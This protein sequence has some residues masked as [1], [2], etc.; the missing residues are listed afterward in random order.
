[1][2]S[3]FKFVLNVKTAE[4]FRPKFL[5]GNSQEKK[6]INPHTA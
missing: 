6:T 5:F 1:M 2:V 4:P 3:V